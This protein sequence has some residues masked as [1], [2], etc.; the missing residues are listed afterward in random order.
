MQRIH[1]YICIYD[2]TC[3][4]LAGFHDQHF[5]FTGQVGSVYAFISAPGLQMNALIREAYTTGV[6]VAGSDLPLG[7]ARH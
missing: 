6:S 4:S 7:R 2:R 1:I 3:L 5:E